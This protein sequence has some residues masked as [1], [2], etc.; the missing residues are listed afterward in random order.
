MIFYSNSKCNMKCLLVYYFWLVR[1]TYR[2]KEGEKGGGKEGE[3]GE[4]GK[5]GQI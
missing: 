3:K 1:G 2:G 4:R 5:E